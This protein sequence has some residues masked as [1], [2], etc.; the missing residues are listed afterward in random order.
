MKIRSSSLPGL[1]VA[2]LFLLFTA[3]TISAQAPQRSRTPLDWSVQ[4]A[5]SQIAR[6]GESLIYRP[7]GR[8]RWDY[9]AGLFTLS[10]IKLAEATGNNSYADYADKAIGSFI[11]PDGTIATYKLDDYNLD[12]I[13]PGKTILALY[14][15]TRREPYR[16]A[17]ELLRSQLKTHP[18]TTEG[19]FWHKK[20]YPWQMW[21][22]GVYMGTPFYAQFTLMFAGPASDF[23]DIAK[24]FELI[25]KHLYDART[26]LYYHGWDEARAQDWA[27]KATGRSSN[28]WGR[29]VGWYAMACVD[30]LDFI[31]TNI[32]K[33]RE[34]ILGQVRKVADGIIRWRDPQSGVWWQVLDKIG[35]P[36]NYR[37][38]SASCMFTYFLAKAVNNK[39][40]PTSYAAHA[41]AAYYAI[42]TNFVR[43]EP[44]GTISLTNCCAVAG[45]GYGRDGSYQ[46]YISEPIVD[47]DLKAV[48]PFILAGI[49]VQKL[50]GLPLGASTTQTAGTVSRSST[51][52]ASGAWA[53]MVR[54]LAG[55]KP[56]VF[57]ER[58]VSVLDHGAV[59]DGRTDCTAAFA[60]AIAACAAAGG[61]TVVVPAGR[62]LTGPIHLKSKVNLHLEGGA[63]L[64]FKTDPKAYLPPVLSRWEGMDC[65]NYSPLI[66]A[67]GQTDVA[68]TGEG[69]LDGQADNSNWWPWKGKKEYG[70]TSGMPNQDNARKRLIR[71][72][73]Q[74]V[75]VEKRVFGEGDYLRPNFIQFYQCTNVLVEGVHIVRSPMWEIHPVLCSNVIIRNTRIVSHGPNNDGCD[76]EACTHVLIEGVLF[77]TGD[78]CIAIKSGRNNDGRRLGAPSQN[79]VIRNCTMRDGHGGVTIGSEISGGCSNVF[80]ENCT[81]DSPNLDRAIRLKS[82][83]VRG[84]VIQNIHVRN[85]TVGRVADAALQIDLLYEEG[86]NGIYRPVVRDLVIQDMSV[87]NCKRVLDV[88]GFPGAEIANVRILNS[89]FA[90]IS[91]P[92]TIQHADVQL[93]GCTVQSK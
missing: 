58:Q 7:G 26:G 46:Y 31:P 40:L 66:Y 45:L 87:A 77:D 37:E 1:A 84:G 38:A 22:D 39:Y 16:K 41:T 55:I 5:E 10:L 51:G 11:Q 9:T 73:E 78:D 42:L 30:V 61:G 52:P 93:I 2:P 12:N 88:R 29:A 50:L 63:T 6:S 28:F 65:Y 86:T 34:V 20:R 48:G 47:N 82:N 56:P 72:V 54:I 19:G 71:M 18:R 70:W 49:E 75:P 81:M 13:N 4:M 67:H 90:G 43:H 80:V 27:D 89:R 35:Q 57:P 76:P 64:L 36:G 83:A 85:I 33:P 14:E 91:K 62:Y 23:E 79:I 53:E 69:T 15:R 3:C 21:L 92:D 25:D 59:A 17:A 68:V 8:A 24:Q 44:D 32:H 60:R 74:N